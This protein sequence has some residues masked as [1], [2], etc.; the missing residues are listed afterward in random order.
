MFY[1]EDKSQSEIQ[2]SHRAKLKWQDRNLPS[3][4]MESFVYSTLAQK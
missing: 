4:E 1:W 2:A 3:V